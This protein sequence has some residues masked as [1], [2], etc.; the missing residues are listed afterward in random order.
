MRLEPW[1][2]AASWFHFLICDFY[3]GL[4]YHVFS[5]KRAISSWIV[6]SHIC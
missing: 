3:T 6:F 2:K 5:C 1:A 4:S